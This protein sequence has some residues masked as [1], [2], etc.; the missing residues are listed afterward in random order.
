MFV[1]IINKEMQINI[2]VGATSLFAI[3]VCV[4]MRILNLIRLPYMPYTVYRKALFVP[5]NIKVKHSD[6][7]QLNPFSSNFP[8][9]KF[10]LNFYPTYLLQ[11]KYAYTHTHPHTH[12]YRMCAL[13]AF[14][15]RILTFT[16]ATVVVA[17]S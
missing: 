9:S 3:N 5:G 7:M 4:W 17:F 13:S 8:F 2:V 1:C 12:A 11:E 6:A 10:K 14:P 15:H 16:G